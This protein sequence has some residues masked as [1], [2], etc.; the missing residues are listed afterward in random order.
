MYYRVCFSTAICV[1]TIK[2][3]IEPIRRTLNH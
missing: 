2:T 1:D 3:N